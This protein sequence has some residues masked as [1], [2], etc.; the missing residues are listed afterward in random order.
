MDT[1][2]EDLIRC[3]F[4]PGL[5]TDPHEIAEICANELLQ[6]ANARTTEDFETTESVARF[7]RKMGMTQEEAD[8][9]APVFLSDLMSGDDMFYWISKHFYYR[10][11]PEV[12][13]PLSQEE[14][15]WFN[16]LPHDRWVS[17]PCPSLVALE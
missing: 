4:S 11:H 7:L 10:C 8:R 1:I 9:L 15:D 13:K 12:C 6:R 5:L 17:D 16:N 2:Q 14:I 3:G